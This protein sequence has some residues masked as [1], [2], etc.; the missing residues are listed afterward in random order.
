VINRKEEEVTAMARETLVQRVAS[1][2]GVDQENCASVIAALVEVIQEALLEGERVD[3]GGVVDLGVVVEPARIRREPSGRFSEITPA[4]RHLHVGIAEPLQERLSKQR[5]AAV[6]LAVPRG[7][8]F[9]AILAEHFARLGWKV[10]RAESAAACRS[11]LEGSQPYLL[12]LDHALKGRDELVAEI[13][14]GWR[15][16]AIP[17]ITMHTRNEDLAHPGGLVVL[18][19]LTAFEPIEV[20]PF[21]RSADQALARAMEE[22]AVFERQLHFRLRARE[23][24][25]LPGFDLADG[26]FKD[27]GFRGDGLVGLTT[28]FREAM[29]NA[30][31]H[32]CREDGKRAIEVELLLD[33]EKLTATIEDEGQG[34]DHCAFRNG[35]R[36]SAPISIARH[37]H[38]SGS[39]GGLGVYLM[40]RCTDRLEYNDRGNR[41]TLTKRRGNEREG[42]GKRAV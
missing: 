8:T 14:S 39:S 22:A 11:L 40:E 35:I 13:K 5:M 34:F 25:I 27:A 15:T 1:R 19:D 29:R 41:V 20:N 4:R 42:K 23:E 3:L 2:A 9:G 7:G 12:V 24:E 31:I 21:L 26:S 30:E 36:K 38:R 17:V 6:L 32:G 33:K 10:E 18:G 16:N 28:A 37:R